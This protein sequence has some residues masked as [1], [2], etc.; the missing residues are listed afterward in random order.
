MIEEVSMTFNGNWYLIIMG[1][2]V[3][4]GLICCKGKRK[5]FFVPAVIISAVILNPLMYEFWN[6]FS[7]YGYWRLLWILPVVPA[8]A[9]IPA[10]A[11][12]WTKNNVVRIVAVGIAVA[13]FVFGGS[14]VFSLWNTHFAEATNP[15]KLPDSVVKVGEALLEINEQ[16]YVVTD[17]SLSQYLRQYSGKIHSMYSRDVVFEGANSPQ[18]KETYENLA[19]SQG[20]MDIVARNM[21]SYGYQYLVTN[22]S[23]E[24]RKAKIEAAGFS[25]VRQVNGYGIYRIEDTVM[26]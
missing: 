12:E 10:Y 2:A 19:S 16:P 23:D 5:L 15:D 26:D 4:A 6:K 25:F 17:S 13:V 18:A 1:I 3:L 20:D 24:A 22:N 14:I 9:M 11:V 21:M 7:A 8:C